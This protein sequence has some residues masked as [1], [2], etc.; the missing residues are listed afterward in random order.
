MPPSMSITAKDTTATST[1]TVSMGI[2]ITAITTK[3]ARSSIPMAPTIPCMPT[4][5][6]ITNITW[7]E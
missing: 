7:G 4:I 6:S 3:A 1:R 5:L 2:I